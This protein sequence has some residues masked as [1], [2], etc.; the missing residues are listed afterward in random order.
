MRR[1]ERDLLS[2]SHA[3]SLHPQVVRNQIAAENEEENEEEDEEENE[4]ENEEE[5]E[6]G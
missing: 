2:E 4:E 1:C 3:A 6:E 5:S